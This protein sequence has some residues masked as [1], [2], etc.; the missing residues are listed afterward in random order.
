M[1]AAIAVCGILSGYQQYRRDGIESIL[2]AYNQLLCSKGRTILVDGCPGVVLGVEPTGSLR[3]RLHS[4]GAT[5]EIFREPG[6][7]S[8]GYNADYPNVRGD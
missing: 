4:S 6:T 2:S 3:I 8:L 1:L 7:I 5:T